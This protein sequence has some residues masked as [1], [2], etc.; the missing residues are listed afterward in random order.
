L[1]A[2]YRAFASLRTSKPYFPQPV[3][4][5]A[6]K[7]CGLRL[8]P[9]FAFSFGLSAFGCISLERL[10]ACSLYLLSALGFQLS[11]VFPGRDGLQ[12]L[13]LCKRRKKEFW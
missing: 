2:G 3:F 7:A 9:V 8:A 12:L 4:L 11:A 10:G 1:I 5:A 13:C 6:A